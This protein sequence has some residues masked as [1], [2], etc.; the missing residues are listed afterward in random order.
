MATILVDYENVQGTK[1][2]KG[3]EYLAENDHLIVF[4]STSCMKIAAEYMDPIKE[5]G[6]KFSI[7]K[8]KK[9]SK[10]ALDFYIA[11]EAG[12]LSALGDTQI[13]LITRDKGFESIADF[14]T[15]NDALKATKLVVCDDIEH[16]LEK[17]TDP[18]D[19]ER[20]KLI[21]QKM[22]TVDLEVEYGRM[23]EANAV[24]E[25]ISQLLQNTEYKPMTDNIVKFFSDNK[26]E[27]SKKLYTGT[28]HEF[29]LKNGVAIYRLLKD[30]V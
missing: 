22:Q 10:N 24:R 19:I 14:F 15:V 3:V 29:G 9:P 26:K 2:L 25:K 13:A 23:Q 27:S 30:V 4:Y 17:L 1:G 12:R 16:G 21:R 7:Y 18:D 6:C 11:T 8:L 20:R 28:L 5:S